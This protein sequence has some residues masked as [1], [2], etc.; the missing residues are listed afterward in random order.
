MALLHAHNS[1]RKLFRALLVALFLPVLPCAQS[2]EEYLVKLHNRAAEIER[3]LRR[4]AQ[5]V[6]I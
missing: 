2:Q 4:R 3:D 6:W 5:V 1:L